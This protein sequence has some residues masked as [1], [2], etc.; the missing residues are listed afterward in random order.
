MGR[1]R[2]SDQTTAALRQEIK[3]GRFRG[4]TILP[5][6]RQLAVSLHVSRTTLRQALA[7][8]IEEGLLSQ[9]HGMG[10]YVTGTD[11]PTNQVPIKEPMVYIGLNGRV[12]QMEE[13]SRGYFGATMD[14]VMA[15]GIGPSDEVFRVIRVLITG[16]RPDAVE[17]TSAPMLLLQGVSPVEASLPAALAARGHRPV[18]RLQRLR[19]GSLSDEDAARLGSAPR[20]A[21]ICVHEVFF[22]AGG[23]CCVL[24][25]AFYPAERLDAVFA[26]ALP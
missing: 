18:K 25:R 22:T 11:S 24:N 26:T 3:G 12:D 10:T 6:E 2:R 13:L 4:A 5:G 19:F 16:G 9:R 17:Y 20:S 8:L 15:F 1:P 7:E 23:G 14:E 21:A